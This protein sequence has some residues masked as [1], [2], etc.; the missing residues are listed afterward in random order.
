MN[1][2]VKYVDPVAVTES[3]EIIELAKSKQDAAMAEA[4]PKAQQNE[5]RLDG[6]ATALSIAKN[7]DL[8]DHQINRALKMVIDNN[9]LPPCFEIVVECPESKS[10]IT[11]SV[12]AILSNINL[13]HNARTQDPIDPQYDKGRFVGKLFLNRKKTV[14]YSYAH[15]G[16]NYTLVGTTKKPSRSLKKVEFLDTSKRSFC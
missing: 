2:R 4:R 9:E 7:S 16:S 3:P 12:G 1:M 10:V 14:L 11:M 5:A 15:G 13:Y 6:D 8:S